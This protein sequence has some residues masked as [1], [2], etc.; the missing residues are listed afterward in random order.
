M[1]IDNEAVSRRGPILI[2]EDEF[3]IAKAIGDEL[4]A[5]GY[6]TVTARTVS[7]GVEAARALDPA[8]IIADRMVDDVDSLTMIDRFGRGEARP[9]VLFVSGLASV[10]ERIRALKGGGDDYLTKPFSLGELSARVGALLRRRQDAAETSLAVGPL[11]LDLLART[12][13]RGARAIELLPAE[14]KLL[15]YLM[16]NA[17]QTVTRAMLL[18]D[19]WGYRAMPR[20]NLVDVH[21]GKLRRKLE[22]DGEPPLLHSVRGVGFTLRVD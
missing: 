9:P 5:E 21:I 10:D 19:V 16:R 6:E 7:D 1:R 4:S 13:A 18:G 8:L 11:R 14:F 20:T 17:G 3:H 2:V 22:A 12:A 15:E